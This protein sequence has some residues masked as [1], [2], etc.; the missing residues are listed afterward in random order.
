[1]FGTDIHD[2]EGVRYLREMLPR[3]FNGFTG[4]AESYTSAIHRGHGK[5]V[6]AAIR[7]LSKDIHG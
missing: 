5:H 1:M 4:D 7:Q 3:P 6:A 2:R